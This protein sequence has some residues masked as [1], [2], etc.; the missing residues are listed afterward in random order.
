M[1][2][3]LFGRK[4]EADDTPACTSSGIVHK[5]NLP[6][7][8]SQMY[9]DEEKQRWRERGKEHLEEEEEDY[10]E[11]P[12]DGEEVPEKKKPKKSAPDAPDHLN[13]L[14]AVP[15][16]LQNSYY[17]NKRKQPAS[18]FRKA[19]DED[20]TSPKS[21][22][23][24][25]PP[26]D[27]TGEDVVM[28]DE[29]GAKPEKPQEKPEKP[30]DPEEKIEEKKEPPPDGDGP[31]SG[32]PAEAGADGPPAGPPAAGPFAAAAS[33]F[34]AATAAT[35]PPAT[36]P[37]APK[38]LG[39]AATKVVNPFA[40]RAMTGAPNPNVPKGFRESAKKQEK[41]KAEK[42][43]KACPYKTPYG[44][45][46]PQANLDD[47]DAEGGGE[48][49]EI[50][51]VQAP[52]PETP[53]PPTPIM[54]SE[55]PGVIWSSMHISAQAKASP[56]EI[57]T[58]APELG[59]TGEEEHAAPPAVP[60]SPL[61]TGMPAYSPFQQPYG[62]P[63]GTSSLPHVRVL[64]KSTELLQA[65]M[66]KEEL[67]EA[68]SE[69]PP[70][71]QI[72]TPEKKD[73]EA[74]CTEYQEVAVVLEAASEK[75]P[76]VQME[77][78]QKDPEAASEKTP[79]VQMETAEKKDPEAASEKPPEVHM[80]TAEKDP[81]ASEK[82]PEVKMETE[83]KPPEVSPRPSDDG[84]NDDFGFFSGDEEVNVKAEEKDTN[85]ASAPVS[86]PATDP[87]SAPPVTVKPSDDANPFA[88]EAPAPVSTPATDPFSAPPVAVKPSDDANRASKAPAPVSMPATDPFSAPPVAWI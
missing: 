28:K 40:P 27:A 35:A 14:M 38:A 21:G 3:R 77:T 64:R 12:V 29:E 31:P 2:G 62:G 82:P 74:S 84:W 85:S 5:V 33:P 9:Y 19:G 60:P 52:R 58:L 30:E 65:E 1:F 88:S 42:K 59:E 70:E 51:F 18:V 87:F 22:T 61:R 48:A 76:E 47:L 80:E 8:P 36:N 78:A 46:Q 37:F 17:E 44:G 81:E 15:T 69:K 45:Q 16:S 66:Q 68:A 6:D 39:G 83:E 57:G 71:V 23:A 54:A 86:M 67:P 55:A 13:A 10:G 49:G 43:S 4:K 73:P 11:P 24:E 7:G 41:K 32:P 20:P 26:P 56:L 25:G 72:K 75:P 79:E 34:A 50:C 53:P 63:E